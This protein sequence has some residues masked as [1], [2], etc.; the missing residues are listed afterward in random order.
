MAQ[1]TVR[2]ISN[3]A[4]LSAGLCASIGLSSCYAPALVAGAGTGAIMATDRRTSGTI[5][6][7]KTI[8]VKAL[9]ILS[10]NKELWKKGHIT[11]ISYNNV[12]LLVGQAP[13]EALKAKA[14]QLVEDIPKVRT[15]YNEITVGPPISYKERSKDTW[16][17][18]Q[19]KTR[20]LSSRTVQ[21]MQ[22]KVITENGILYLMGLLTEREEDE[23]IRL[24]KQIKGVKS[25]I[26]MF[27]TIET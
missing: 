4:L 12:L 9:H 3:I 13:T 23:V 25:I 27:E 16:I 19:M 20:L 21:P 6:D 26:K 10:N 11:A 2:T 8:E 14:A 24:A 1:M 15:V 7:D 5:V 18:T 17:T 22:V